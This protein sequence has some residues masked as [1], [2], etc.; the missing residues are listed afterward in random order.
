MEPRDNARFV[1]LTGFAPARQRSGSGSVNMSV[2]TPPRRFHSSEPEWIDRPDADPAWVRA[3]LRALEKANRHLGGH[4][5]MVDYVKMLIAGKGQSPVSILDLGTG[6]AD[7]PRAVV[8]W[9]RQV[10]RPVS[11]VAVDNNPVA[12]AEA[13][14][15]CR[16]WPEI[17]LEAQELRQLP[18]SPGSFDLVLCSLTLHHFD[19][20]EAVD[21]LRRMSEIA[22][23]GFVINDLR[24][25]WC[26]IWA[27]ELLA[28]T[29][30]RSPILRHDAPQSCRAAFT[31]GELRDLARGAGLKQFQINRHHTTFR[32]V[33]CGKK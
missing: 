14:E 15:A 12:L 8:A 18:Y 29:V 25:N 27:T 7:I 11:V 33:L 1:G 22:R 21:L 10:R 3:E 6:S 9:A 31:V 5:L 16:D 32:M 26:A 2:L 4:R 23:V 17:K 13:R 24:R 19:E 30:L 28:R 20:R